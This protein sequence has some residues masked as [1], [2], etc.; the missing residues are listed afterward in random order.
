MNSK[1]RKRIRPLGIDRLPNPVGTGLQAAMNA[2]FSTTSPMDFDVMAEEWDQLLILD[3]CRY[4]MFERL[5]T[6][7]G[8]LE[9]RISVATETPAFLDRT[10]E[11][12]RYSDTVYVTAN[13]I[14]RVEE[15]CDVD[16]D[17][18]FHEIVD[19][20]QDQWDETLG[21]VRPEAMA[22]AVKRARVQYPDHRLIAHFVQP[23]YPFIGPV[24]RSLD[25][26]GMNGKH[27]VE[28]EGPDADEQ[29]VW[30]E[31]RDGNL[32]SE[33]VRRAYDEN[34]WL[35]FPYLR[36]LLTEFQG[37]TVIT[38]DHGN[39]L[40]EIAAPF[41]VRLYGHP[42]DIRTS[43]LI[44]V[45]WLTVEH[46]QN[47]E[48]RP[49]RTNHPIAESES[50]DS[51]AVSSTDGGKN[52]P[53]RRSR[54]CST[55]TPASDHQIHSPAA[56][57]RIVRDGPLVSVVI[58]THYRNETLE[59]AIES[60]RDQRYDPIELVVVDDSGDGHARPVAD[61]YDVTYLEH[62]KTRG[63]NAARTT[64]IESA[65]GRYIQLLDDDDRLH[66]EKIAQQVTVLETNPSAGVV[67][68]GHLSDA[69]ARL[70][71]PAVCGEVLEEALQFGP[72]ACT[73]STMLISA[74]VLEDIAP[75]ADTEGA[76]DIGF[77]IELAACTDFEVITDALV[78]KE[79]A[80]DSRSNKPE[81]ARELLNV[82]DEYD[83]LYA[84]YPG[85]V[86]RTA[87]KK[88][89]TT[90]AQNTLYAQK[91]SPTAVSAF[92]KSL[93]YKKD[94]SGADYAL[95]LVAL[96][97]SPGYRLASGLHAYLRA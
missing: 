80:N 11:G 67:Y 23:H 18:V 3:G 97:G 86:R 66:P 89:Y 17:G 35:T 88:A 91:W 57:K 82:I 7:D 20:W 2:Y 14:H 6:F 39:H 29:P 34:L 48:R 92:Y 78:Y 90:L 50:V 27:R 70:P 84:E 52:E 79:T 4:D 73:N 68:C 43:E 94:A 61:A 37:T 46:G 16:L 45:P 41:P 10:F 69:G 74:P 56:G 62:K 13:P 26:G 49:A 38:S 53:A 55:E 25:H 59:W 75:L 21:T 93:K 58:P 9:P 8:D 83:S 32:T 87:L 60:V 24:G 76:D 30:G 85:A 63:A 51:L 71:N 31:L 64:G 42:P 95:P 5:N 22:R 72:K 33:Q 54:V 47:R 44:E 1:T 40:G 15:W 65:T 19:V 36:D 12:N 28:G 77:C 81:V 96:F